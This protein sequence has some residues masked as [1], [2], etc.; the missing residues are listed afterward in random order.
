MT[1]SVTSELEGY[2]SRKKD[3]ISF[4]N[5]KPTIIFS[6]QVPFQKCEKKKEKKRAL[7]L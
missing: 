3:V 7:K 1:M 4:C 6:L 2:F 5:I